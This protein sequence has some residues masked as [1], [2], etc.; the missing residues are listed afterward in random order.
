MWQHYTQKLVGFFCPKASYCILFS[1]LLSLHI[2]FF[3]LLGV[4]VANGG[5]G[6]D[7]YCSAPSIVAEFA[8]TIAVQ[9]AESN[10]IHG[11]CKDVDMTNLLS[12]LH[13]KEISRFLHCNRLPARSETQEIITG[14]HLNVSYCVLL[15]NGELIVNPRVWSHTGSSATWS[16]WTLPR[17]YLCPNDTPRSNHSLL[18]TVK[19]T[20]I[21]LGES[22]AM[23]Y[24]IYSASFEQPS[25][26]F[27]QTAVH[28][29]RGF[30]PLCD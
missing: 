24:T 15:L 3:V 22:V 16:Q 10:P 27:I 30:F 20:G 5:I 1:Y 11:A 28:I 4:L 25:A 12:W 19:L 8:N 7:D 17:S 26:L 14:I 13:L 2:C 9:N 21:K 6:S 18:H 23:N 29:L